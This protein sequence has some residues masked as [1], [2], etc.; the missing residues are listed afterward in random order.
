MKNIAASA[1]L[2]RTAVKKPLLFYSFLALGITVFLYLTLT[3][4][5]ETS[6]G[7]KTL[8]WMIFVKAGRGL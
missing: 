4:H 2:M 3:T 5:I 7:T 8:L 1:K 6:D